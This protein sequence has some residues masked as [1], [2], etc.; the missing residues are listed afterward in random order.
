MTIKVNKRKFDD[1][2]NFSD[3]SNSLKSIKIELDSNNNIQQKYLHNL[4][5][6]LN[7]IDHLEKKVKYL[8]E[9]VN[10]LKDIIFNKNNHQSSYIS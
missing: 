1:V 6:K 8:E 5:S 4:E 7:K 9:E 2:F 3:V 10:L